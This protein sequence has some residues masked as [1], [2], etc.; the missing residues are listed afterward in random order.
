[1][2]CL[3]GLLEFTGDLGRSFAIDEVTA[4]GFLFFCQA[5]VWM[6]EG[7][8]RHIF[9]FAVLAASVLI[10]VDRREEPS[11][12]NTY[13]RYTSFFHKMHKMPVTE[14]KLFCCFMSG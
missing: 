9:E 4:D 13:T 1:M 3:A 8:L 5:H 6:F 10:K 7:R 2:D 11:V 14:V 12:N